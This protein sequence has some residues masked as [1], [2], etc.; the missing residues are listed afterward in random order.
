MTACI[1]LNKC[2]FF[3]DLMENI[4]SV[5]EFCKTRYCKGDNSDCAIYLVSKAHGMDRVPPD[6]LPNHGDPPGIFCSESL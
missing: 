4:T 3:N 5:A 6:L 2:P 1:F